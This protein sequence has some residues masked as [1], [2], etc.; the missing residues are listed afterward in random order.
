MSC[1]NC[2]C[3]KSKETKIDPEEYEELKEYL[4]DEIHEYK[5]IDYINEQ[6]EHSTYV[7]VEFEDYV[8]ELENLDTNNLNLD[9]IIDTIIKNNIK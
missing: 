4:Q 2:K 5:V 1:P 7:E 3:N 8:I 9:I 6:N